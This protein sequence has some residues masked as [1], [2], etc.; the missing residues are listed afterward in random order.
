LLIFPPLLPPLSP[1]DNF[2]AATDCTELDKSMLTF[3]KVAAPPPPN[4]LPIFA[5]AVLG[6]LMAALN[7]L[8]SG[9]DRM[10]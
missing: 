2:G 3:S 7:W 8:L 5:I 4:C 1:S 9:T 6:V 10:P